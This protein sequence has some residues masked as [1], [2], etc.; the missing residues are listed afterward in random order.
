MHK[1]IQFL[2]NFNMKQELQIF[3]DVNQSRLDLHLFN[4]LIIGMT[5][6][7]L[8]NW[9]RILYHNDRWDIIC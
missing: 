9:I 3:N 6:F 5:D 1:N 2:N 8:W 7:I 4:K